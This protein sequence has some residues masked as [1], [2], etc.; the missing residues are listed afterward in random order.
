MSAILRIRY[1]IV[2]QVDL[3]NALLHELDR[4]HHSGRLIIV[5]HGLFRVSGKYEEQC[6]KVTKR[7]LNG[8]VNRVRFS[9]VFWCS[10]RSHRSDWSIRHLFFSRIVSEISRAITAFFPPCRFRFLHG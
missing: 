4:H 8:I 3:T 6:H 7:C 9:H 10:Y 2:V 1:C 5:Q